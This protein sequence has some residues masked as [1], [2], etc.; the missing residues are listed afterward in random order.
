VV[1]MLL[2][3]A[4][5]TPAAAAVDGAH[6]WTRQFGTTQ[7]DWVLGVAVDATGVYAA[8]STYGN[9]QGTNKGDHDGFIRKYNHNGTLLWTRQF[10]TTQ[11]D[12]VRGVAVDDTGVYTAGLTSGSLK[13]TSKGENDGFIRKYNHNGK[14]LWTRQFGTTQWDHV[15]GVAV[16][17]TGVYV[18]GHTYGNLQG[19]NKG[20]YD[21]FVR[22]YNHNGKLLWTRQFGTTQ[23]DYISGVAVDDTGVYAGGDTYGSLQGTNKK[24]EDGFVRKYGTG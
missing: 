13:G 4:M 15:N 10:G 12:I 11:S 6:L 16:D 20:E 7:G 1:V 22:K 3:G 21:G 24:Q 19:A 23:S 5:A 14:L 9:L 18:A 2:L 8:G 17:A